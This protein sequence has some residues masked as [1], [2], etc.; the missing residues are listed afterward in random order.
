MN[1]NYK[2]AYQKASA[3]C[4]MSE[5]CEQDVRKKL[6]KWEVFKQDADRIIAQLKLDDFLNDIRYCEAFV[7]DKFRFNRWGK[8][9]IAF[10]LKTKNLP[11]E[12]I[13]DAIDKIDED[14]YLSS[15]QELLNAKKRTIKKGT[16]Y[17]I[18]VKL[19]KFA[20]SRGFESDLVKQLI[21]DN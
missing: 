5:K 3:F 11:S 13:Y 19:Y 6:Q 10:E 15:L 21:I 18:Q 14:E 8:V 2:E 20:L 16:Q 4:A 17:E 1:N 12:A 7:K 9:K